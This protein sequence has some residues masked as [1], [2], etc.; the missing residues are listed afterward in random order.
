M[1][2]LAA[3]LIASFIVMVWVLIFALVW[4]AVYAILK[5]AK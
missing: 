3:L 1:I 5:G 4:V 2:S